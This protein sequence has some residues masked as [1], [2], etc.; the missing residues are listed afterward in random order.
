VNQATAIV[1]AAIAVEGVEFFSTPDHEPYALIPLGDHRECWPLG[2]AAFRRWVERRYYQDAHKVANRQSIR[3]AL[4]LLE[5]MASF[6]GVQQQVHVRLAEANGEIWVDLADDYW[7]AVRVTSAGWD[8]VHNPPVRFRRANGMLP[9]PCPERGG[10]IDALREFVNVTDD[11]WTLFL[12]WVI[13]ALRPRGPYPILILH[14]EQGS[15]KSTVSRIARALVDPNVAP[16]RRAP[17][18]AEDVIVAARNGQVVA[19]DNVSFLNQDLSDDLARLAT[20]AGFGTRQLYTNLDEVIVQVA[21]PIVLNSITEV[22]TRGDLVDRGIVLSLPKIPTYQAEEIFWR[23]FDAAHPAIFGALLDALVLGLR[24]LPSTMAPNTRMADFARWV[25]AAEPGMGGAAGTFAQRYRRNKSSAVDVVLEESL[26]AAPVI[27]LAASG[28]AGTA[29]ELRAR[30]EELV[31][32]EVRK[33]REWP[34]RPNRLSGELRRIAP[35]LRQKGIEVNWPN[36][37]TTRRM[38]EIHMLGDGH[39]GHDGG[40]P[41]LSD[42]APE[43]H[44]AL[45]TGRDEM[46]DEEVVRQFAHWYPGKHDPEPTIAQ[47]RQLVVDCIAT[48]KAMGGR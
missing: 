43:S 9:L 39:D 3:E 35:A 25:T 26:I 45:P 28:F 31:P 33:R 1:D 19:Y 44:D 32:D 34:A 5:G 27:E 6:D 16:A 30:L 11:D 23:K 4:D 2:S 17:K 8:V 42:G 48:E 40:S 46:S 20:G 22:A 47:M 13:G 12:A 10:N 18:N 37:T 14:G 7:Q 38:I 24:N 15:A 36:R 29:S 21:R 41:G